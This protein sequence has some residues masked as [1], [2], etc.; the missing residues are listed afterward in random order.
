MS[1]LSEFRA[2]PGA[3]RQLTHSIRAVADLAR[4]AG[5][6]EARLEELERS[7][8]AWEAKM[9]A[10]LQKASSTYKS[11]SNA[12][13]RART[14]ER[15]AEKLTDPF[16]EEG[17]PIQAGIPPEYARISAEEEVPALR[18]DVAPRNSKTL[19]QRLKFL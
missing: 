2:L 11:A 16:A 6:G 18:V 9:E 4:E 15:H 8:A 5:P 14:M 13:S 10:E 3:I 7:R 1:V 12:E 19:A 17:E